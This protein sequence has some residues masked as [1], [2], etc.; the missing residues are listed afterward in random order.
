MANSRD[1]EIDIVGNDRTR[2]ATQSASRNL[3]QLEGDTRSFGRTA[4]VGVQALSKWVSIVSTAG[5][6][7]IPAAAAA[8]KFAVAVGKVTAQVAPAAAALLPLAAG[9]VLVKKTLTAAGPAMLAA[10]EPVTKAWEQQ[11]VVIGELSSKGLK[12]LA[13]DFVKLNMPAVNRATESI[14]RSTN[15]VT[16]EYLKWI[17]TTS[18]Q[19][20]INRIS[21]DTAATFKRLAPT[22][23]A[24]AKSVT[25]LAGRASSTSFENFGDAAEAVLKK[26][27]RVVDGISAADVRDAFTKLRDLGRDLGAGL[28]KVGDAAKWLGD[29]SDDLLKFADALAVAGIVAGIAAGPVGWIYALIAAAGLLFRHWDKI[30]PVFDRVGQ[31]LKGAGDKFGSLKQPLNAAKGFINDVKAGF[32][33]FVDKVK[34]SVGPAIDRIKDA[35]IRMQPYISLVI[36]VLGKLIKKLLQVAGPVVGQI[37][38]GVSFLIE[39]FS[40][41]AEAVTEMAA[42][43]L[44]KFASIVGPIAKL[45]KKMHLPYAKELGAMAG[46]AKNAAAK[47]RSNLAQAKS[48]LAQ[49]EVERLQK[50]INSLRG[51]KVKT[52]ADKAEINRSIAKIAELQKKIRNTQGKSVNV[53]VTTTFYQK[54]KAPGSYGNGLGVLLDGGSSWS[55]TDGGA[56]YRAAGAQPIINVGETMVDSRVYIDGAMIDSRTRATV[57]DASDRSAYRARIGRR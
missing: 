44:E 36:T 10:I 52:E 4:L 37:I 45:A 55:N 33:D 18:G 5:A 9:A 1:V 25:E 54:G 39:A 42:T 31:A 41:V 46:D 3:R 40:Y 20:V 30:K 26:I 34:P 50:R 47:I 56:Q 57:R 51:K 19:K 32:K 24:V 21:S 35:W 23:G 29:H 13:A 22:V 53:R 49:R 15:K 6:T 14:A 17:N 38:T 28:R 12:P 43:I 7:A 16:R 48:D 2:A 11:T 27:K 8:A